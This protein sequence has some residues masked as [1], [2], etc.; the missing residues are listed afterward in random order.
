MMAFLGTVFVGLIVGLI[1]RAIKPGDDKMGWIM[2]IVLGILG[3]VAAGYVGR[4]LGMYQPGQPAGW[5]ASVIG[6]IVLLAIYDMVRR[7]A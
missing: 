2:T 1:A 5:I 6:A 3:S 4:A 7:K